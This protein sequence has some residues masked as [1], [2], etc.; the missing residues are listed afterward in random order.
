VRAEG[1]P[2]E[3][4]AADLVPWPQV[5]RN[6]RAPRRSEWESSPLADA[7]DKVRAQL[8]NSGRVVVRPSGTE[9]VLRIMVEAR[10]A[11]VAASTAAHLE[12]IATKE[13]A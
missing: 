7:V 4:L 13:L 11:T 12:K 1:Q 2:L 10:D 6:V 5:M 3:K 8:G 9:P